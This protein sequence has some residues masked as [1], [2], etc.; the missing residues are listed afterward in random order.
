MNRSEYVE[1][2][3]DVP[4]ARFV[5]LRLDASHFRE[6]NRRPVLNLTTRRRTEPMSAYCINKQMDTVPV[7]RSLRDHLM[8]TIVRGGTGSSG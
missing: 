3:N 1:P 5:S 6:Q 2:A 8:V 7:A 4:A